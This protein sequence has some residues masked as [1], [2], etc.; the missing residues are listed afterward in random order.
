MSRIMVTGGAGFIGSNLVEELVRLNHE[1]VVVDNL[2]YGLKKNLNSVWKKISFKKIDICDL[3]K[4]KKVMKNVDYVFHLAAIA[5]VPYSMQHPKETHD[6]NVDG[7]LNVL[8]AAK[9]SGVK[10]V[11]FASSAAVYGNTK[12]LPV[13][14][15]NELSPESPY[16]VHKLMGEQYCEM[17]NKA[18]GLRTTALRFFNVYG[19]RQ[20]VDSP[21][22]GVISKF[23]SVMKQGKQPVVFGDG[24]QTRDFVNIKDVVKVFISTMN[25][26]ESDG[27]VYNIATGKKTSLLDLINAINKFFGKNLKPVFKQTRTGDV[28]HSVANIDKAKKDL[29]FKPEVSLN[30]GIKVL[31]K[32]D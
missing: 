25:N 11:V 4:L 13:K 24:L 20:R 1:A 21:Y 3:R 32:N 5:S 17:F 2:S 10:K 19:P 16:A 8:L 18:Y 6:V 31:I 12:K 29:A 28:K 26:K 23:V 7:T 22:S 14:E 9:T 15:T 27:K 30:K